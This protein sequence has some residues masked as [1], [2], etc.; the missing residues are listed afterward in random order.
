M[1]LPDGTITQSYVLHQG[2]IVP[3]SLAMTGL[4]PYVARPDRTPEAQSPSL[5]PPSGYILEAFRAS[6]NVIVSVKKGGHL[7]SGIPVRFEASSAY[8]NLRTVERLS[9]ANGQIVLHKLAIRDSSVPLRASVAGQFVVCS[10]DRPAGVVPALSILPLPTQPAPAMASA[11]AA[12]ASGPTIPYLPAP[13]ARSSIQPASAAMPPPS[14]EAT[15]ADVSTPAPGVMWVLHAGMLR[16]QLQ[17]W[18]ATEGYQIIW[19]AQNDFDLETGAEFQGDFVTVIQ[20]LFSH[21][22]DQG[23]PLRVT[24]YQPNRVVTVSED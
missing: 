9:D 6:G 13:Q 23:M 16:S 5:D 22:H 2:R 18:G 10:L 1:R 20:R 14:S 8:P 17:R 7:Q 24:I 15:L 11:T 3:G 4:P 21:L 19:S 12:P